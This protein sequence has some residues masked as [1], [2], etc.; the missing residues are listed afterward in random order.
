M[1]NITGITRGDIESIPSFITDLN[2]ARLVVYPTL[3][4]PHTIRI[5]AFATNPFC[6]SR[7]EKP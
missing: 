5:V 2:Q 3:A 7:E 4:L 1:N 6:L